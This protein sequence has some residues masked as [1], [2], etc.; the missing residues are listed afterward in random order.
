VRIT[1]SSGKPQS[2]SSADSGTSGETRVVSNAGACRTIEQAV[3][4]AD[5]TKKTEQVRAC[6]GRQGWEAET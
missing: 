4:L 2:W 3:T 1:A 5:G 6:R